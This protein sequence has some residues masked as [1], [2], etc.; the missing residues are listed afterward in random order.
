[1]I[2]S[3]KSGQVGSAMVQQLKGAMENEK[4]AI[5]LFVTLEDPTQPMKLE[6]D[7]AGIYHSELWDQDYPKV[8]ILSIRELLAGRHPEL[9]PSKLPT[10]QKAQPH[11]GAAGEQEK[12]F[13]RGR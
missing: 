7:R 4:A 11:L 6:A 9:P 2:V 5:G 8:Q 1:V 3:V 13:E 10:F 12:L